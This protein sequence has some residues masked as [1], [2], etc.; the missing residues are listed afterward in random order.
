MSRFQTS[1]VLQ[2]LAGDVPWTCDSDGNPLI[3][4]LIFCQVPDLLSSDELVVPCHTRNDLYKWG[5][6]LLCYRT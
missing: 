6:Q 2:I 4:F 3:N 5:E 1:G